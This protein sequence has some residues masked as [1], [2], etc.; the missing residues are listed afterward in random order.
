MTSGERT[1]N[2][3]SSLQCRHFL[4]GQ[5][6]ALFR[7]DDKARRDENLTKTTACTSTTAAAGKPVPAGA[8]AWTRADESLSAADTQS[9][10]VAARIRWI[11]RLD[12]NAGHRVWG[13]GTTHTWR[14]GECCDDVAAIRRVHR[15]DRRPK[16][17][18]SECGR[19]PRLHNGRAARH[20]D[21]REER[22]ARGRPSAS[23]PG[24]CHGG[25]TRW[26][27]NTNDKDR[28]LSTCWRWG[29]KPARLRWSYS[30]GAGYAAGAVR[31]ALLPVRGP[32]G[33]ALRHVD[34]RSFKSLQMTAPSAQ[35]GDLHRQ[36]AKAASLTRHSAQQ[37]VWPIRSAVCSHGAAGE[38]CGAWGRLVQ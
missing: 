2:T 25:Y 33:P 31:G 34:S 13:R 38:R 17:V 8:S 7:P 32:Y 29:T 1:P 10:S 4:R 11:D 35:V 16:S 21:S 27:T 24:H 22:T 14:R 36:S 12:R 26:G 19:R 3:S 5:S 28:H 37:A 6:F 18:R 20:A 30:R 9:S 15:F 23:A